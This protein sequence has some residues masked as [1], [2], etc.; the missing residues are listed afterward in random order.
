MHLALM[1]TNTQSLVDLLE[2]IFG[3]PPTDSDIEELEA[4]SLKCKCAKAA[5]T[6]E[7]D[8]IT[9]GEHDPSKDIK[10]VK[11]EDDLTPIDYGLDP[12]LVPSVTDVIVKEPNG[13]K[14]T[15]V[16]YQCKSCAHKA[17]NC[18]SMMNHARRC[19]NICLQ[20]FVCD[21]SADSSKSINNH[22]C[23]EH[24]LASTMELA[25]ITKQEA[26]EVVEAIFHGQ[27]H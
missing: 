6:E 14:V 27:K 9:K 1:G 24:C 18:T 25:P 19:L 15:K 2:E 16:Y 20:C 23:K 12:D 4:P 13:S 22:I 3:D 17:Q 11:M 10:Y 26:T 5:A 8:A 7:A 21:Y